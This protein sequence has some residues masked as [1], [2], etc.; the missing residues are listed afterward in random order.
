MVFLLCMV[1]SSGAV[2]CALLPTLPSTRDQT[3]HLALSGHSANIYQMNKVASET[4][5]QIGLDASITHSDNGLDFSFSVL[6]ILV[7]K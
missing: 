2:A 7:I 3:Q 1:S 4:G 6:T 5:S